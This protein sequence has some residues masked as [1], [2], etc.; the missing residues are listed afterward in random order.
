[1]LVIEGLWGVQ[2]SGEETLAEDGDRLFYRAERAG[3]IDG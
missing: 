2:L 1:M 3:G